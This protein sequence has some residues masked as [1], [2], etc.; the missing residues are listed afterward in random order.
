MNEKLHS[1]YKMI[2]SKRG[3]VANIHRAFEAFPEAIEAHFKYYDSIMLAEKLPLSRAEREWIGF[4]TSFQNE[5][6]Y[7]VTHHKKTYEVFS[8]SDI[9]EK[10]K[11][12]LMKLIIDMTKEPTKG[13]RAY[14]N[15]LNEGFTKAEAQHAVTLA[16]Y[17]NFVTRCAHALGVEL[18]ED[19]ITTCR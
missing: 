2:E 8:R 7:C 17:F 6:S 12:A 9:P 18:E 19:Y 1:I 5:C 13:N 14:L 16:A 15:L 4:Q 3:G 11:E 10:R